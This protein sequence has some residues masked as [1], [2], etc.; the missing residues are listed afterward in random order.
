[1]R[2]ITLGLDGASYEL[3]NQYISIGLL[4]TF[5]KLIE[6]GIYYPLK[7]TTPPHT[8]PGWVSSLTGVNPG[9]HGVYQ[10]WDTQS[11]TYT[12]KIM[13]SSDYGVSPI[14]NILNN[15]GFTTGMVNIPMSHPPQRC[16]GYMLTWPLSNTTRYSYPTNLTKELAENNVF[17]IPDLYTMFTGDLKYVEQA[18]QVIQQ[19][20]TTIKYLLRRKPCDFFMAVF[21]EIDRISHFYWQYSEDD[22]ASEELRDAIKNIYIEIDSVIKSVLEELDDNT[23]LLIYSDHGFEKGKLDFYVHTYLEQHNM[24]KWKP[25]EKDYI[26]QNTWF[27]KR[28][29]DMIYVV[30]WEKTS[31]YMASPGSYGININL[32]GRQMQGIVAEENYSQ[33]CDYIIEIM[34][35]VLEPKTMSPLFKKVLKSSEIYYGDKA[36]NAPDIML[37]PAKY[38][39]MVHHG[40]NRDELFSFQPEQSGMHSQNGIMILYGKKV[41]D[42]ISHHEPTDICDIAPSI[43]TIFDIVPPDYMDGKSIFNF[44]SKLEITNTLYMDSMRYKDRNKTAYDIKEQEEVKQRLKSLGY[45]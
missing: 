17:H 14:W 31:A 7:S 19:R 2:L 6:Q 38:G 27:E 25:A 18:I 43:L 22:K 30:D 32:K 23:I 3:I 40:T 4:P 39:S 36:K 41:G 10:F 11:S 20:L 9:K 35:R 5:K 21:T 1:M 44:N 29:N 26:L 42:I 12:G 34:K 8:A 15:Y 13:G 33:L 24:F 37:I 28:V 45:L 16:N